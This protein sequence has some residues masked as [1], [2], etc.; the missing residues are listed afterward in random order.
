MSPSAETSRRDFLRK[1]GLIAAALPFSGYL[2]ACSPDGSGGGGNGSAVK[3]LQLAWILEPRSMD[4]LIVGDTPRDLFAWFNVA[5]TLTWR[6]SSDNSIQPLL[7]NEWTADGNTWTFNLRDDVTFHDGKTFGADDVVEALEIVL[8]PDS[9]AEQNVSYL[10]PLKGVKKVDDVTVQFVTQ[11]PDPV[12][13]ARLALV[14]IP[15]AGST[16]EEAT[17]NLLGTGPYKMTE[18]NRGSDV[19]LEARDDHWAEKGIYERIVVKFIPEESIRLSSLEAGE[20]HFAQNLSPEL[21]EQ[22]PKVASGPLSTT[23]MLRLNATGDGPMSDLRVRQAVNYALDRDALIENVYG[24][25]ADPADGQLLAEF[26]FGYNPDIEPYAYDPERARELIKEAGAEGAEVR[27]SGSTGRT[28]KDKEVAEAAEAMINEVGLSVKA[29]FPSFE[30]WV[31]QIFVAA[32]DD[33]KAPDMMFIG[34]GNEMFDPEQSIGLYLLCE[35]DAATYCNPE[36]DKLINTAREELDED[37]R[38]AAYQ[39]MWETVNQ[40]AAYAAIANLAQIHGLQDNMSW[41]PRPDG[42]VVFDETSFS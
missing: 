35:G 37:R 20:V 24:G 10:G 39:A 36:V 28:V 33:S 42:V 3:E 16:R 23:A 17:E 21:S 11:Y 1:G 25:F 14:G 38:S 19:V 15:P 9:G 18:W 13:P 2:L 31:E 30:R 8:D 6:N 26:G 34:H 5:Q 41:T 29:E 12:L 27:L 22:A 32:E 40:D 7:A 4:Y